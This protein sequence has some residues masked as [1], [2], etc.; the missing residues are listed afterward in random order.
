MK[1]KINFKKGQT[2]QEDNEQIWIVEFCRENPKYN[3]YLIRLSAFPIVKAL[4]TTSYHFQPA[5][6]Y[7]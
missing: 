4:Q 1:E 2:G 3:K 7:N 5:D 6:M